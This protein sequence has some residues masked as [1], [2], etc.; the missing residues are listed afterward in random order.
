MFSITF[1][2]VKCSAIIPQASWPTNNFPK[3]A[4]PDALRCFAKRHFCTAFVFCC[5]KNTAASNTFVTFC[6]AEHFPLENVQHH[7]NVRTA[8][9]FCCAKNT[10]ASNTFLQSK[11]KQ[12]NAQAIVLDVWL[13]V[14]PIGVWLHFALQNA[15]HHAY[16]HAYTML[17]L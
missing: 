12:R 17:F 16:H 15:H 10:A 7:Q 13:D 9:V 1:Y 11:A 6:F 14:P 8:F 4:W 5:A 2:K 3:K